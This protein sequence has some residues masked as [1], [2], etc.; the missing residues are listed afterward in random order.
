MTIKIPPSDLDFKIQTIKEVS[1]YKWAANS[2][3]I[4][5]DDGL[6]LIV[7]SPKFKLKAGMKAK[8]YGGSHWG[9]IVRGI[10]IV[11]GPVI[12]YKTA[13]ESKAEKERRRQRMSKKMNAEKKREIE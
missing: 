5:W 4:T 13:E 6:S 1:K 8:V 11:D 2:Y 3:D 9:G 12:Y 10:E 7:R